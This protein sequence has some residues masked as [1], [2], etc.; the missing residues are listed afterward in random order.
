MELNN[1]EINALP[2][3]PEHDSLRPNKGRLRPK[4]Q[5]VPGRLHALEGTP[6][7]IFGDEENKEPKE[8]KF[9]HLWAPD[10]QTPCTQNRSEWGSE[11]PV[12]D[13]HPAIK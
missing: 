8:S 9:R 3:F 6:Y 13:G 1:P 2:L 12:D 5:G 4:S 10:G 7:S 11:G